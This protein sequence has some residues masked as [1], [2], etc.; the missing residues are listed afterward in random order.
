MG[1]KISTK[2]PVV[3]NMTCRCGGNSRNRL[4]SAG[5]HFADLT[6]LFAGVDAPVYKDS[7]CHLNLDGN[8][9]LAEAIAGHVSEGAEGTEGAAAAAETSQGTAASHP[10]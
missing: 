5:V 3:N 4:A 1:R 2:V 6:Q 8:R 7:C 9:R 10:K